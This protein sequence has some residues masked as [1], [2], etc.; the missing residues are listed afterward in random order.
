[1]RGKIGNRNRAS[2]I[3]DYS[4]IRI[5]NITP[6]D[7]DGIIDYKNRLWIIIE[8]KYG[9]TQLPKG[10]R[11]ALERLTDNLS[12]SKPTI[13]FVS[14]HW[15]DESEDIDAAN[16]QLSEFRHNGKWKYVVDDV[17]LIDAING[18]VSQN[19]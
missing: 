12:L 5:K 8:L 1:L 19:T 11:L 9:N 4:G 14:S 10:Q 6:T 2:L 15:S 7:I 17:I 16:T 3:R 18:F 13:C